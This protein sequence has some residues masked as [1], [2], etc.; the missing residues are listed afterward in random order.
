M[1]SRV[2]EPAGL[3][4]DPHF[5]GVTLL[6]VDIDGTLTDGT[7]FWGG[8][9]VGWTQR[10]SV[11]DGEAI[12]R[13]VGKGVKVV[14]LSRNPSLCAKTR[15]EGL[16][17]P[18]EWVG[19]SDKVAALE[20]IVARHGVAIENVCYFA[21][22]RED[23]PI[24]QKVGLPCAVADAHPAAKAAAKYVTANRGGEHALEEIADLIW[25]ARGWQA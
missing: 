4:M 10:F 12:R 25:E 22:G 2:I 23:V 16:G 1:K 9:S 11:R 6:L 14:P 7:I 13:L 3:H 18:T 15:M 17:L 19:V 5:R 21:D 8:P 24:L 20:Q